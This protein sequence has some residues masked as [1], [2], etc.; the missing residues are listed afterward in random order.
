MLAASL[1]A[2]VVLRHA[3]PTI[4]PDLR[5]PLVVAKNWHNFGQ[6]VWLTMFISVVIA[7]VPY[8]ALLS[9]ISRDAERVRLSHVIFFCLTS[10]SVCLTMPVIFSSDVYAYAAYGWMDAHGISP[11]AHGILPMQDPLIRSAVWQWSNPLPVCVYG[12]LFVWI[13]KITVST[14]ATYGVW[15]QLFALRLISSAALAICG[16]LIF[17]ALDGFRREHR[18]AA[19]LG[20]TLNPIALWTAAEGHNDPIMLAVVLIGLIV[21]RKFGHFAGAFVIA[22]SALI[23]APGAAAGIAL[24]VLAWPNRRRFLSIV[25]GLAGGV[26][27]TGILARPFES[28]ISRIL[29]PHGRYTPQFS[30]QYLGAQIAHAM[31][32]NQ[33][34]AM[35]LGIAVAL[36][37]AGVLM[38]HGIRLALTGDRTGVAVM[39]LALWLAIP[40]PYPWY[41]LWILPIAFVCTRHHLP[42]DAAGR[43]H[44]V[45]IGQ[46]ADGHGAWNLLRVGK[47]R[48]QIVADFA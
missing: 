35:E 3:P 22:A 9:S 5:Q 38:L 43:H 4:A 2:S 48:G 19:A 28:G 24:A 27:L 30:A 36:V 46:N 37:A 20:V 33:I 18:L 47:I 12:P 34:H 6:I 26:A 21:V 15:A 7:T 17:L 44:A 39:T 23:K 16:P 25:A 42:D 29:I 11:Y 10:L 45:G 40:N 32:G 31:F 8:V 1:T 13:A 14:T 41:A